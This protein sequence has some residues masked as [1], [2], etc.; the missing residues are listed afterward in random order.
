M[1]EAVPEEA[2]EVAIAEAVVASAAEVETEAEE[3]ASAEVPLV[4]EAEA[5]DLNGLRKF[6]ERMNE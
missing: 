3:V 2:S 1:A 5:S 6:N 4:E